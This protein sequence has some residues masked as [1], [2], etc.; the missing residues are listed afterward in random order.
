MGSCPYIAD[1]MVEGHMYND[2]EVTRIAHIRRM[3]LLEEA[4]IARL[5]KNARADRIGY[6]DRILSKSGDLL[7]ALG[8]YLKQCQDQ[9]VELQHSM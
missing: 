1:F 2:Y 3:E 4:R 6:T 7:I 8:Q 5:V 9:D